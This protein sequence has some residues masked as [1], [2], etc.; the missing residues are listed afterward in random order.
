MA[1]GA[2]Q[3]GDVLACEEFGEFTVVA[4]PVSVPFALRGDECWCAFSFGFFLVGEG[5]ERVSGPVDV[6]IFM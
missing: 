5:T 6:Q 3:A 1:G 2:L 4:M